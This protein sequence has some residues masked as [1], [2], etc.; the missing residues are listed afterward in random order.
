MLAG[1]FFGMLLFDTAVSLAT[2]LRKLSKS[3]WP[4]QHATE[5][6]SVPFGLRLVVPKVA[7]WTDKK[8]SPNGYRLA[9]LRLPKRTSRHTETACH[10]GP[11]C[12]FGL[13]L[14]VPNV[15]FWTDKKI[16]PN[17]YRLAALRLP[18]RTSRHT[19][20][21]CGWSCQRSLSELIRK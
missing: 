3:K 8:I 7:F 6:R 5:G 16:S 9:A 15:A 19:E 2:D 13:R 18:K 4:K 10:W 1:W 11:K 14:V 21:A 20:T 12:A 17:G